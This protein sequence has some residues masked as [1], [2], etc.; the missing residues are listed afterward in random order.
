[1]PAGVRLP[2]VELDGVAARDIAHLVAAIGE[3]DFAAAS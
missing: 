3:R 1:M 2:L